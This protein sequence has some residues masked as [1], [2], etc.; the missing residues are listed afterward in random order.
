MSS[1]TYTVS[2][3]GFGLKTRPL[4]LSR[5]ATYLRFVI[6]GTDGQTLDALDQVDDKVEPGET[7][8][9]AKID[10]DIGV[11]HVDGTRDAKRFGE[12][13]Q[14]A[15]YRVVPC[16]LTQEQLADF[17]QWSDWCYKQAG[18]TKEKP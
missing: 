15:N 9:P 4:Q 18:M 13:R 5:L 3:V 6:Q 14:Y 16:E 7:I 11:V 12:W 17:G 1:Q 2:L 10:G 8:I